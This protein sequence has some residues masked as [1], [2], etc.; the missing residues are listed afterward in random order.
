[1]SETLKRLEQHHSA[2]PSRWREA[3]EQRR[4]G[5]EWLRYSQHIAIRMLDRMEEQDITQK[6][7]AERMGCSQQYV[8][9][10]LKGCE[11]LSLETL[12][13]IEQALNIAVVQAE[14]A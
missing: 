5:K 10:I 9:R 2:T 7:L 13:K 8:S 1:M 3:A 14:Q 12:F 6:Q 4:T 11:N